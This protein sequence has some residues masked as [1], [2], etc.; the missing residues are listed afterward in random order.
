[1]DADSSPFS[2]NAGLHDILSL[3]FAR[4]DGLS[5]YA[6]AATCKMW[7]GCAVA[8]RE[9]DDIK[10]KLN[11]FDLVRR[12]ELLEWAKKGGFLPALDK[13]AS[14]PYGMLAVRM[15]IF[16]VSMENLASLQWLRK[17]NF[18]WAAWTCAF[19]ARGGHLALLQWARKNG[20]PWDF[21]T[22]HNAAGGGHLEV[23]RWA[24]RKSTRLNYNHRY[25]SHV[26]F[27]L[28]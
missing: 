26:S 7:H 18:P 22:C 15:T 1:M 12:V 14:D 8:S 2:E 17:N 19:A 4:L 20:C 24:D 10:F 6:A 21:E 9:K 25:I 16:A 27:Y 3:V 5:L 11:K 23:L 28:K 13:E